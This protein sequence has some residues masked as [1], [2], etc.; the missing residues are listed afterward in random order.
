MQLDNEF[1]Q[2]AMSMLP[3]AAYYNEKINTL[4][5]ASF[6]NSTSTLLLLLSRPPDRLEEGE[7]EPTDE[8]SDQP[9][10]TTVDSD[11]KNS[12]G[13]R[14]WS[15][16]THLRLHSITVSKIMVTQQRSDLLRPSLSFASL[17][18]LVKMIHARSCGGGSN[19]KNESVQAM[20]ALLELWIRDA[21]QL[22]LF[23]FAIKNLDSMSLL[24][25]IEG[26]C[27]GLALKFEIPMYY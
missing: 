2:G 19:T 25:V 20:E 5:V 12:T 26:F 22:F 13:L 23:S 9:S 10:V 15:S 24:R 16:T 27:I 18:G 8:A 17:I 1:V 6:T 4:I 14:F 21:L 7:K 11:T 3:W